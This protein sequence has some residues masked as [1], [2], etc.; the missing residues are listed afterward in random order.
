MPVA[1]TARK[2]PDVHGHVCPQYAFSGAISL[3]FGQQ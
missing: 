2:V 3:M 1:C